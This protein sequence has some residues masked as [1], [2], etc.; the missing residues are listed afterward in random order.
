MNVRD[1]VLRN[2]ARERLFAAELAEVLDVPVAAVTRSERVPLRQVWLIAAA[3]LLGV[4]VTV[5]LG[6]EWRAT[7]V[8]QKVEELEPPQPLPILVWLENSG[9]IAGFPAETQSLL[10][11]WRKDHSDLAALERFQ[12]LCNL[13]VLGEPQAGEWGD[14]VLA[15]LASLPELV[16]LEVNVKALTDVHL[17]ALRAAPKLRYLTLRLDRPLCVA[18]VR[19]LQQLPHLRWLT[20]SGGSVDAEVVRSLASLPKVEVLGLGAVAG[21]TEE[22]LRELR[23]LHGLRRVELRDFGPRPCAEKLGHGSN[24][25]SVGLTVVV[26]KALAELPLLEEVRLENCAVTA[27]A[28]SALPEKLSGFAMT[29]CPDAGADVVLAL[30]RF[31]GL[32][33][34]E[35]DRF[36]R[37]SWFPAP[38]V[39]AP[40]SVGPPVHDPTVEGMPEQSAVWRAQAEL[41]RRLPVERLRYHHGLPKEVAA[42][43]PEAARLGH[44]ELIRGG[45]ADVGPVAAAPA[46]QNLLLNSCAVSIEDLAPLAAAPQL[47]EL[48][49]RWCSLRSRAALADLLP[50]VRIVVEM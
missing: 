3:V 36:E 21:C 1:E 8:A 47:A 2:T 25:D 5:F 44:V 28:I 19:A 27:A 31:R 49:M 48:H 22:V 12:A 14:D 39:P 13:R 43:L 50:G 9:D 15:P 7:V 46:L 37:S 40:L 16:A 45:A 33:R 23:S 4:L 35:L 38:P 17:L 6:V 26:A 24:Q 32:R 10:Y 11:R 42:A 30:H 20:L 34:L 41:L 18:D 29:R